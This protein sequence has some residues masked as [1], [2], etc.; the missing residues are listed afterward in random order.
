MALNNPQV[1]LVRLVESGSPDRIFMYVTTHLDSSNYQANG[2]ISVT[3]PDGS[4]QMGISLSVTTSGVALRLNKPIVH[5]IELEGI[6]DITSIVSSEVK[7][8]MSSTLLGSSIVHH[9]E[10]ETV[11]KPITGKPF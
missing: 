7:I 3:G 1:Q 2:C 6:D 9:D 4:G 11:V 10:S 5:Q 8:Y